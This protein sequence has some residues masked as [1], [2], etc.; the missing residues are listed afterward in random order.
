[1]TAPHSTDLDT[2]GSGH[3]AAGGLANTTGALRTRSA[4]T[5]QLDPYRAGLELGESLAEIRPEVVFLFSSIHYRGDAELLAGVYEAVDD[6]ALALIGNTGD[7]FFATARLGT[8][9][10]AALGLNSEGRIRWKAVGSRAGPGPDREA[11]EASVRKLEG[12]F[13]DDELRLVFAVAGVHTDGALLTSILNERLHVPVVGGLAGDDRKM[14][15]SFVYANREVLPEGVALLG[16]GGDVAFDIRVA[17]TLHPV[18]HSGTVTGSEGTVLAEIDGLPAI[19]FVEREAGKPVLQA[20][21]GVSAFALS[22]PD[23]PTLQYVRSIADFH[24]SGTISLFGG[25]RQS[26]RVQFCH[27]SPEVMIDDVRAV[28]GKPL[29]ARFAPSA[30]LVVSCAGR[31]WVLGD[32][33]SREVEA[34]QSSLGRPLEI[35]GFPSY[36]EIAPRE[37]AHGYTRSLFHNVTCVLLLLGAR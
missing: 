18:G 30:A 37:L 13:A 4:V 22:D 16:I 2:V 10:A 17:S 11:V 12:Q 9:G 24:S 31:K 1:M 15:T 7:G 3:S 36:G 27:A 5:S 6:P 28:A 19:E 26:D 35:A 29:P 32:E 23:E 21:K 8:V 34:I 33:M 25:I 20:D 14:Q